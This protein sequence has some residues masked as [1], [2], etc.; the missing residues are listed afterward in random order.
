V[1]TVGHRDELPDRLDA[2]RDRLDQRQERQV[3]EEDLVLGVVGDVDD[4]V[5]M[6]TRVQRVQHRT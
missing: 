4:L 2:M 1:R 5:G 6:Q 3:E